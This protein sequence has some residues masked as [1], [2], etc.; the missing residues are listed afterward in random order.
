[1]KNNLSLIKALFVTELYYPEDVSTGYFLTGIAEGLTS[2]NVDVSVLCSRPS[3]R[4]LKENILNRETRNGVK[5]YRISV[6]FLNH[7]NLIAKFIKQLLLTCKFYLRLK[8]SSADYDI[9][10]IATNPP[11][12]PW[13]VSKLANRLNAKLLLLIHDVYPDVFIPTGILTRKN[14]LY[15]L[16]ERIQKEILMRMDHII[17]LGRDM[18]KLILG[19][20][21][22]NND[23]LSMITN[24]GDTDSI[25]P[26]LSEDNPLRNK[27]GLQNKFIIQFSGNIGLTHGVHDLMELS[28]AFHGDQRF[29]FFVFGEGSG[30]H[31]I[32]KAIETGEIDNL[33]LLDSCKRDE[34]S[35]YLNVC[36]LFLMPF[37]EGMEGISVP[38][39]IY[40][41]LAAGNPILAVTSKQSELS[42]VIEEENIGWVVQTGDV[43]AMKKI[44]LEAYDNPKVLMQMSKKARSV[45]E[46]KYNKGKVIHQFYNLFEKM[47]HN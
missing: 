39:R 11:T 20:G 25:T 29:H 42:F 38:S 26:N 24:W 43:D 31:I 2:K 40:N 32:Q 19:K 33:T 16:L 35:L 7:N 46:H 1:M 37:K 22:M 23:N 15:K 41:V 21:L 13:V 14:P 5:I 6:P 12:M 18:R 10:L 45:V 8:K 47:I 36:D 4:S 44:V 9:I 34:L 30:K 27:L 17:V 3:Y 28:K